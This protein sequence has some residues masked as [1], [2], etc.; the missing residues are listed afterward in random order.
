L[1]V[2]GGMFLIPFESFLQVKSP[3]AR[4]G[5]IIA[6]SNFMS[7]LG[8]LISSVSLYILSHVLKLSASRGFFFLGIIT[9]VFSFINTGRLSDV[10]FPYISKNF[11]KHFYK[12]NITKIP[13]KNSIIVLK[14]YSWAQALTLFSKIDNLKIIT[15]GKKFKDFPYFNW[16]SNTISMISNAKY[17]ISRLKEAAG[18][19]PEKDAII[20]LLLKTPLSYQEIKEVFKEKSSVFLLTPRTEKEI[21]KFLGKSFFRTT[22]NFDLQ[23]I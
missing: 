21:K 4:R 6:A 14:D 5:Q 7:F 17:S 8:G 1:G 22:F 19:I 9:F 16:L 23:K 18:K 11:L 2:F 12:M 10:F 15:S 3:E 20:C 13:P